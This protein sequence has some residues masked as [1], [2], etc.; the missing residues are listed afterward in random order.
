MTE[1]RRKF[2]A[3]GFEDQSATPEEMKP[4]L[5][6]WHRTFA[7][8][9][10]DVKAAPTLDTIDMPESRIANFPEAIKDI[11]RTDRYE[12]RVGKECRSRWSPYH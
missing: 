11:C 4:V 7:V 8:D 10:F 6:T 2:Y 5:D 3:W 1:R 12:R 9:A